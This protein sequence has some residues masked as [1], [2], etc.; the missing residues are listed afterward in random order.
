MYY[1][2]TIAGGTS[3]TRSMEIP[4]KRLSSCRSAAE[5]AFKKMKHPQPRATCS[6]PPSRS[7]S[8][9]KN[10]GGTSLNEIKSLARTKGVAA[11][12][13]GRRRKARAWSDQQ[14][15]SPPVVAETSNPGGLGKSG[16]RT[17]TFLSKRK[18]LHSVLNINSSGELASRTRRAFGL[19]EFRAD[20]ALNE[21]IPSQQLTRLSVLVSRKVDAVG[22]RRELLAAR[23]R[24]S[25]TGRG[26]GSPRWNAANRQAG[27]FPG[28]PGAVLSPELI[29]P[30]IKRLGAR[31]AACILPAAYGNLPPSPQFR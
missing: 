24:F 7:C 26:P 6:A 15:A 21:I 16:G 23:A 8:S 25:S 20:V 27:R 12:S 13:S 30:K 28:E 2:E 1:D 19:Q 9:Y 4:I 31:T 11:G 29:S 10:F 5:T 18:A 14:P 17:W 3:A 22:P